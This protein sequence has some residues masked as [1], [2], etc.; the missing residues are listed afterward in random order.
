MPLTIGFVLD[1]SLDR[2]DGV[3]QYVIT[4]GEWLRRQGHTVHYLTSSTHRSDLQ[5]IHTL[6]SNIGVRFNGNGLRMPLPASRRRIR[7]LLA[8]EQFDILH[9]QMPFSPLLAGRI[10]DAAGPNTAVVGT[11]HMY[12]RTWLVSWASHVLAWWSRRELRRFDTVMSVSPAAQ[13]FARRAFHVQSV[14][15]PNSISLS[16]FATAKPLLLHKKAGVVHVLFLGRLVERKGCMQLLRAVRYLHRDANIPLF[17]VTICGKGPLDASLKRYVRM[18]HMQQLV[19]F[20][21]FVSE[22]LKPRYFASADITVFPS[23]GGESFGI[24]LLEAMAA[25]NAAVIAGDNPG[26]RSVLE[27]CPGEVLV[28]VSNVPVFSKKLRELLENHAL[29]QRIAQWQQRRAAQFDTAQLGPIV[30]QNYR[31]ALQ[32][33]KNM[34]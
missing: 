3:Q 26:Y 28:D 27:H 29:R 16:Q 33:R 5:N 13:A 19:T 25:G 6:S 22:A 12:P 34:R 23:F 10:I 18:N 2:P 7:Q 8:Y 17:H 21:G 24:V 4:T 20:E 31:T 11:F 14:V 9:V 1:D 30:V 32:D 15:V